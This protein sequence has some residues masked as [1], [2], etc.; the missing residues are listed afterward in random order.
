MDD[1]NDDGDGVWPAGTYEIEQE[2]DKEHAEHP[3]SA[4]LTGCGDGG[5]GSI[6][7]YGTAAIKTEERQETARGSR[8]P[9][10]KFKRLAEEC[11]RNGVEETEE[12]S[13]SLKPAHP[14]AVRWAQ[15]QKHDMFR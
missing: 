5:H 10:C 4:L 12:P 15:Q 14:T 2:G 9:A 8:P 11:R 6:E 3:S 1:D 13:N 7:E